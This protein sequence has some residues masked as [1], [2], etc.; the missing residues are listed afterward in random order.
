MVLGESENKS[1]THEE[2]NRCCLLGNFYVP[3]KIQRSDTI[4]LAVVTDGR[5]CGIWAVNCNWNAGNGW[6]V[7][8]NAISNPNDWNAGN[9]VFS[10]D[11]LL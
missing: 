8:A 10:R 3:N 6:N 11:S 9:Q 7:E 5:R 2:E 4:L 1:F